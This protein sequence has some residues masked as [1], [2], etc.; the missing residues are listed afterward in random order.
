MYCDYIFIKAERAL[1]ELCYREMWE[2]LKKQA[3]KCTVVLPKGPAVATS[4][5]RDYPVYFMD[6][7]GCILKPN[8]R[9]LTNP[10]QLIGWEAK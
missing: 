10:D 9:P 5:E 7:A 1:R 4:E 8:P 2:D 3:A 6:Y